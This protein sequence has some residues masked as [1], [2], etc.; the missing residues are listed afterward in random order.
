MRTSLDPLSNTT[1]MGMKI[2]PTTM[3]AVMTG[4]GVRIGCQAFSCCCLKAVTDIQKEV[5]REREKKYWKKRWRRR[6]D[7]AQKSRRDRRNQ[8]L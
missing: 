4:K 1:P 3:K 7:R 8:S 5:E 2:I 6:E